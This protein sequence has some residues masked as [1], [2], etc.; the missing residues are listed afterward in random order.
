MSLE[1][2][3]MYDLTSKE[4]EQV[5][6]MRHRVAKRMRQIQIENARHSAIS[7][8]SEAF[9]IIKDLGEVQ[10]KQDWLAASK[11]MGTKLR[12]YEFTSNRAD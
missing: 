5:E 4:Q 8:L 1:N 10:V 3:D 2:D 6:A 12:T 9:Q 7:T 11:R